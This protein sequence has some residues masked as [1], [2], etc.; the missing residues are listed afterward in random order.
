MAPRALC[1]AVALAA[2]HVAR[3]AL[4]WGERVDASNFQGKHWCGGEAM[5]AR[6]E[7]A[8]DAAAVV[9]HASSVKAVGAG[10]SWNAL[11]CAGGGVQLIARDVRSVPGGSRVALDAGRRVVVVDAGVRLRALLDYLS[12][13]GDGDGYTLAAFPWFLD[14][15]VGGAVAT[16][17]HGSSLRHGSLSQQLEAMTVV[18]ANGTVAS[19]S[20]ARDPF[21]FD[22][23]SVSVG[24]LGVLIDVTLRVVPNAAVRRTVRDTL[25]REFGH[26]LDV[27]QREAL[28]CEAMF[29]GGEERESRGR[30]LIASPA[31]ARLDATQ[32]MWFVPLGKLSRV[33][34]TPLDVEPRDAVRPAETTASAFSGA[35]HLPPV[36]A[37]PAPAEDVEEF[38]AWLE[39][40]EDGEAFDVLQSS[41]YYVPLNT[42]AAIEPSVSEAAIIQAMAGPGEGYGA[43]AFDQPW[44]A[45]RQLA[46]VNLAF[47]ANPQFWART[48][49]ANVEENL[50]EGTFQ[51]RDSY[52]TMMEWQ[53]DR[54]DSLAAYDQ[55]EVAIPLTRA[56]DCWRELERSIYGDEERWRAFRTQ[57]LVRFVSEETAFL[58]PTFDGA[59]MYINIEDYL[60]YNTLRG[61][62]P[63]FLEVMRLLRGPTCA[64]RL[65]WGKAGWEEP[66]GCWR[67][68]AEYP[69][70]WCHFGCAVR[71][72]DPSGKFASAR[73]DVFRWDDAMLDRCCGEAGFES[74]RDCVCTPEP[75]PADC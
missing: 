37:P 31:V 49:L 44:N 54:I 17:T 15:S 20:R 57:A 3:A 1:A 66:A 67:G 34:F 7:S 24:R 50:A 55:Y 27:V 71:E 4:G 22:A 14:Q 75:L 6:P 41:G 59:G 48:F 9:A 51:A 70:S 19:F 35:T 39:G 28:A 74:G 33:T 12:S 26:E 38:A 36:W 8:G 61:E 47:G 46:P 5:L 45:P 63:Q 32:L 23:L 42:S 13:A 60:R 25:P 11:S 65:H 68:A 69:N 18:L 72:L 52:I 21:L 64:G 30:C 56:G 40:T 58:S 16:A 73:P 53:Y 2:C 62:N 43:E 29:P 10:H